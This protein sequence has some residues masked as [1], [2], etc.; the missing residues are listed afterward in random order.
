MKNENYC[1]N[2][3]N[4]ISNADRYDWKL[5]IDA[6]YCSDKT[7]KDLSGEVLSKLI[8]VK[9]QGGFRYLGK[10]QTPNLVVLFTS[11]EDIYWHDEFD[12]SNGVFIYYGDNRIPGTDL[13][14]TKLHGNEI[15]KYI[16]SLASNLNFEIR[17]NIP[18]IFVFKKH[19]G[20][21]VKF[22]GLAV[23]GVKGIPSKDWLNAVWGCNKNG[24]RFQNYKAYFTILDTS[25]GS[26]FDDGF[27]INLG[28][29]NDIESGKA[30]ESNYAPSEWKKYIS[31]K[32]FK[33]LSSHVE[34]FV[35]TK[36]EQLP[37]DKLKMDM[38]KYIQKYFV[39]K[40]RGY[41][42]ELFAS[43]ITQG[44]DLSI[45]SITITQPYKDGGVDGIGKYKIFDKSERKIF[46]D[47]FL[48]AKCYSVNNA[49]TVKDTA[50][51]ISRIKSRDFGIMFTTSY[52]AAQA[53]QELLSDNHPVVIINGKNI[54]EFIY[55][56][57]EIR[58]MDNLKKWLQLN[59]GE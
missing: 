34:K 20:R 15:L 17:K 41:S 38:L 12:S 53:Y 27:G 11:G 10:T 35:K 22:V 7:K 54:I 28:W 2:V 6:V 4:K 29:I 57:L 42:F 49:V 40:D 23:P 46:I 32:N 18:P 8:G 25:N 55:N 30:Y 37:K 48:Q 24:D 36:N 43:N 47:F 19:V 1:F 5:F 33:N 13:H 45:E 59:Y 50:R 9:N 26:E 44:M 39:S 14:K 51:L 58:S 3:Y 31:N 16:F 21:D 56:E 52:V